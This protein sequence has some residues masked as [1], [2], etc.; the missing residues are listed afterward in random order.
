MQAHT[1]TAVDQPENRQQDETTLEWF[2]RSLAKPKEEDM[3]EMIRWTQQRIIKE[4]MVEYHAR[5]IEK[6]IPMLKRL[7]N[8]PHV[9]DRILMK[10]TILL[11]VTADYLAET[12]QSVF[13]MDVT[14]NRQAW[15]RWMKR[16]E[17]RAVY[18][19]IFSAMESEVLN[20]ELSAIRAAT[21]T[22]RVSAARA[23]EVRASLLEHDNP[24]VQ[25]TAA[26]DVLQSASSDTASKQ[27]IRVQAAL[28]EGQVEELLARAN[29]ELTKWSQLPPLTDSNDRQSIV[30]VDMPTKQATIEGDD[31][32][33]EGRTGQSKHG[34]ADQ[35]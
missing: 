11:I 2:A 32:P 14:A 19:D 3:S 22:T 8:V 26:R 13:D 29:A 9:H 16:P 17:I 5:W 12:R 6:T 1:N 15:T 27:S 7:D 30:V 34:P 28:S 24:W 4:Q 33:V 21:R 35:E 25:L 18:D 23:A 31:P 20:H 10:R